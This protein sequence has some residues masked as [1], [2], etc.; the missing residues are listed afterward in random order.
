[1]H[2]LRKY[3][4]TFFSGLS[5]LKGGAQAAHYKSYMLGAVYAFM[6]N[7]NRDTAFAVYRLFFSAC[8]EK[9]DGDI[10]SFLEQYA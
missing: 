3:V 2:N 10:L 8:R 9:G 6:A 1:M 5:G 4:V 7:E